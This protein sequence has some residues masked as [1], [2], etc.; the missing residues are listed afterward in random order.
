M[1]YVNKTIFMIVG[2]YLSL[3][4]KTKLSPKKLAAASDVFLYDGE[5]APLTCMA[6]C[7]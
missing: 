7:C 1:R 3:K 5:N 4:T 2:V 6:V